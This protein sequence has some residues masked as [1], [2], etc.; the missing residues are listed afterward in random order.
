MAHKHSPAIW[1]LSHSVRDAMCLWR[2]LCFQLLYTDSCHDGS[3]AEGLLPGRQMVKQRVVFCMNDFI[4]DKRRVTFK[5]FLHDHHQETLTTL[6]HIP[7][8]VTWVLEY[9]VQDVKIWLNPLL[10]QVLCCFKQKPVYEP[11]LPGTASG[12]YTIVSLCIRS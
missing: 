10:I 4:T 9:T 12:S 2:N 6:V 11:G 7:F 1:L 3:Q 5:M 8:C